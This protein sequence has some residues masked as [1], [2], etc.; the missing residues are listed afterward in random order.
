MILNN[1]YI[2]KFC[3][4][5]LSIMI[6]SYYYVNKYLK[7]TPICYLFGNN[8][9]SINSINSTNIDDTNII[10]SHNIKYN[11]QICHINTNNINTNNINTNNN[12]Y[13]NEIITIKKQVV[14]STLHDL[15]K[16]YN[17]TKN[18]LVKIYNNIISAEYICGNMTNSVLLS[19]EQYNQIDNILFTP[20]FVLY[21]LETQYK[22][23]EYVFNNT[24]SVV[25]LDNQMNC[26]YLNY[27]SYCKICIDPI[28]YKHNENKTLIQE[29]DYTWN[30]D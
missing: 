7:Y 9:H 13:N 16:D 27:N 8:N 2:K 17:I 18:K 4:W 30:C 10:I 20:G 11:N 12:D 1:A 15:H 23:T 19:C 3:F 5:G 21:L 24:Y 26:V 14:Y 28:K 22:S 6:D 29:T 25:L